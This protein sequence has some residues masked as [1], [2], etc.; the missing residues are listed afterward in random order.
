MK[1]T[2]AE[3]DY[4]LHLLPFKQAL[5][6]LREELEMIEKSGK[7]TLWYY[8]GRKTL[9]RLKKGKILIDKGIKGGLSL[10]PH[11]VNNIIYALLRKLER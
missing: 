10:T 5:K 9:S 1:E 8:S 4:Y 7:K 3:K 11:D 6:A 2:F